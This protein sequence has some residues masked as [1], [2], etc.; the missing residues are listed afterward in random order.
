MEQE[1]CESVQTERK[2]KFI[3]QGVCNALTFRL[4]CKDD[5]H[6]QYFFLL[7]L[8]HKWL[9]LF[10]CV[11]TSLVHIRQTLCTDIRA[12][13]KGWREEHPISGSQEDFGC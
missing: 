13:L 2:T 12:G 11:K 8:G 7:Y 6:S 9:P 1:V 3:S 5:T 10:H 4:L